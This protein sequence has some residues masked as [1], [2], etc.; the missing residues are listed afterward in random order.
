MFLRS[1]DFDFFAKII[2]GNY[3]FGCSSHISFNPTSHLKY[4]FN[5]NGYTILMMLA[6]L[7]TLSLLEIKLFEN[8]FCP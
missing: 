1:T 7:A 6:K 4:C 3:V 8:N 5:K 2:G